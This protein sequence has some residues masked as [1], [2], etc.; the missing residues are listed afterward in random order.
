MRNARWWVAAITTSVVAA[1][2]SPVATSAT[3]DS[4]ANGPGAPPI[5][6]DPTPSSLGLVLEEYATLPAST[7][8]GPWTDTR[9][10]TRHN[11]INH[12]GELPDGSGRLFVPDLNT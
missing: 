6:P 11:R 1:A 8:N 4:S 10:G 9:I 7:P 12:V 2:L 3:A 5:P